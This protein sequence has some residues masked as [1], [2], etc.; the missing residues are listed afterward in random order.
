MIKKRILIVEDDEDITEIMTM[1]LETEN[2]DVYSVSNPLNALEEARKCNPQAI[3]LDL[4][5]PQM[6]GW[7]LYKKLRSDPDFSTIPVAIVTAKS[8]EFDAVV[9]LHVMR[10]D[11]YITK[12]FGK[13]QLIDSVK[14][15]FSE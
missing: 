11:A 10:A 4:T 14:K 1:V 5:M 7:E 2:F 13:Q 8:E 3:L 6:S 15:L 12:P 9:G